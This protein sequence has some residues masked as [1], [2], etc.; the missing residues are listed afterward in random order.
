MARDIPQLIRSVIAATEPLEVLNA[1]DTR[2]GPLNA[3]WTG[4]IDPFQDD[5][6]GWRDLVYH[7]SVPVKFRQEYR[8]ALKQF[9]MSVV[10]RFLLTNPLPFT[11]SESRQRLKPRGRDK[12]WYELLQDHGLRDG[13]VVL[14]NHRMVAYWSDRDIKA[15]D[16]QTRYSL[17]ALSSTGIY[18][19][20]EMMRRK[21]PITVELSPR[22]LAV[23]EYLA[24]GLRI[25]EIARRT[26]LSDHTIRIYLTRAQKKLGAVTPTHATVIAARQ[27]LI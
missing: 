6:G 7:D 5:A 9:G 25:P 11:F 24:L 23:L 14:Q 8:S 15:L 18:R 27:R 20:E 12:W 13:F 1:L 19:L 26:E 17:N 16:R 21:A 3:G 2:A 22:E 10:T 4:T